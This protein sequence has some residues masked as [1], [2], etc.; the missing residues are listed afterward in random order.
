MK[1]VMSDKGLRDAVIAELEWDPKIDATHIGVSAHSGGVALDG[2][3]TSYAQKYAAVRAAERV[4]GVSAVADE[5]EVELPAAGKRTDAE[6][7][8]EIARQRQWNTLI[9]DS[10]E[11][12]VRDG[13]VTLTGAVEWGYQREDAVRAIRHLAGVRNLTNLITL[14]P[15]HQPKP[16]DVVRRVEDAIERMADIDAR[17][18]WVTTDNGTVHLHGRVHSVAGSRIAEH[19]AAAAPGVSRVVNE[20]IVSP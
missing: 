6:I 17:S 4:Y 7:S 13:K 1:T 18:I 9:P 8:E 11:A 20:L 12:E 19:A 3:V 14:K 2:Y 10:V 5:L 15:R 16:S